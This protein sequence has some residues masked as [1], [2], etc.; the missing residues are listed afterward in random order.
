MQCKKS[1]YGKDRSQIMAIF[2]DGDLASLCIS[3]LYILKKHY[4]SHCEVE[5]RA[6]GMNRSEILEG[7]KPAEK[8]LHGDSHTMAY[9][10]SPVKQESVL[11]KVSAYSGG[12]MRPT[13]LVRRKNYAS[14]PHRWRR[15]PPS[16][17]AK[18]EE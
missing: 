13:A 10:V 12:D 8:M 15:K 2:S 4:V 14:G 5:T 9:F 6:T 11:L 18:A 7:R 16:V 17:S 1:L 3:K